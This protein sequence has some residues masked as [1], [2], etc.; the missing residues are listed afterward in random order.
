MAEFTAHAPGTFCW[1]ELATTDQKGAGRFYSALLG[2]DLNDQ[3]TGPSETYTMFML[4][5][6]EVAAACTLRPEERQQGT[7]AHWRSYVTVANADD[8]VSRAKGLGGT[9]LVPPFDVMDAGRM[10]VLQDPTGAVISIWQPARHIGAKILREPGALG[11][12]ELLT[13]DTAAAEK[14]YTQLF[15]WEAKT[16]GDGGSAYTEFKVGGQPDA[17]MMQIDRAWGDVPPNWIPYF[18]V[19]DC[20]ATVEKCKTLGGR[21][22]VPPTDIEHVGRFAQLADPQGGRFS[23]IRITNR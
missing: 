11:W 22:E 20:D 18:Q 4:R 13:R 1:P 12:T 6:R 19:A 3:Q 9:V 21:A 7:P 14:F 2:W 8:T 16:G 17:G 15:G 10:A 23:V 5:G